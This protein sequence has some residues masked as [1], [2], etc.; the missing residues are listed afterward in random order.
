[1]SK[2]RI[3]EA[4][5]MT[6]KSRTTIYRDIDNGRVS[7]E[8]DEQGVKVIDVAELQRVYGNLTRQDETQSGTKVGQYETKCDNL[9]QD[10][11]QIMDS[12]NTQMLIET[13]REQIALL[14][15][16]L[17]QATQRETLLLQMLANEQ[18]K[19]KMLMLPA[20][21]TKLGEWL[22]KL[23]IYKNETKESTK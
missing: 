8:V 2:I 13:L 10:E 7:A 9:K 22:Q 21:K 15:T 18:Q 11:K 17:E 20:P 12:D 1:M 19:T 16:Q 14:K 5:Q 6:G 3:S 4:E 23:G